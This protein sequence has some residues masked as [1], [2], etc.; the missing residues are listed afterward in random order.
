MTN[1][2][3]TKQKAL[4]AAL[5]AAG[6]RTYPEVPE[7]VAPP[8]QYLLLRSLTIG[9][10]L[11]EWQ[12]EFG[13]VHVARPG[14]NAV[15]AEQVTDLAVETINALK[16]IDGFSVSDPALE[17]PARFEINGQPTLACLVIA[18]TRITRAE[19]EGSS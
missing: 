7:K 8:F 4:A 13:I 14:A 12:A 1:A 18:S 5:T 9:S 2:I 15:M 17:Q 19:M 16:G 3:W 6:G 11:G 10:T